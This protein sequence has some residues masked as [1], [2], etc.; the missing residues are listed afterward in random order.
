MPNDDFAVQELQRLVNIFVAPAPRRGRITRNGHPVKRRRSARER[1]SQRQKVYDSERA[2]FGQINT[3]SN[4]TWKSL[5]EVE[6]WMQ[7][8]IYKSAYLTKKYPILKRY[9]ID[10]RPGAGARNAFAK[11]GDG[12]ITLPLW[13]RREWV[14]CHEIT[15]IIND[16]QVAWHGWQFCEVYLDIV[17][18]TMGKDA[19]D[20]LK[21]QFKAHRVKFSKPRAKRELTEEQR[22]VLRQR[23]AVARAARTVK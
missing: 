9:H 7:R 4:A 2:A 10:L 13:A 11:P 8:K 6:R 15:H 5:D 17:R 18:H 1:D 16:P 23:M 20:K 22:E 3:P 19:H 14:V 12:S 21:A